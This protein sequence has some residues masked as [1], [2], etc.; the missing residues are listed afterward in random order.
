MDQTAVRRVLA[1]GAHPDDIEILCGGTLAR[2][3]A[4]GVEVVFLTVANGDK[5]SFDTPPDK[6]AE[7]R[8]KECRAAAAVIGARWVGLGVPDGTVARDKELHVRLIQALQDIDPDVIITHSPQDYMSDHTE[9][10]KAVVDASFYTVCPQFCAPNAQPCSRVVPVYFMDTLCGVEF[11]PQEY[12]DITATL[13]TKL[14]MVSKHESQHGYLSERANADMSDVVR[15]SA[16]YRGLQCG[17]E[18]AEAFSRH[19]AWSRLS[20]V[21]HLP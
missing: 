13:D 15:T 9:T 20:C 16:H 1:V 17:T 4:D 8:R 3:A 21:R 6:L 12:V 19:K 14:E 11:V 18:Y 5:G 10:A 7:I 2:F